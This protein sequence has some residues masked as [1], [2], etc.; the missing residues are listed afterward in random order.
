MLENK[1]QVMKK[2]PLLLLFLSTAF[3]GSAQTYSDDIAP[4]I[5]NNCTSCHRSGEIGPMSLTNYEEVSQW[6]QTIAY[7]TEAKYMPPWKPDKD[8]STFIGE[9]GLTEDQIQLIQDWVAAGTP[10]G[11]PANEP[12]VPTFPDGSQLGT[13]DLVLTMEEAYTVAGNNQDDYRVFVLPTSE[14]VD[15][16]IAAIE[17]RPGNASIVHHAL[18]AFDETGEAATLDAQTPEYGYFSYGDFGIG[19][20][21]FNTGYTPGILTVPYPA[22]IGDVLPAGADVLIQVHYAPVAS[23]ASDLSSVNIFFKDDNDPIQRPIQS[24]LVLPNILPN[25]WNDFYFLPNQEKTI[26]GS[27]Q[28]PADISLFQVY[29]HGHLLCK[30]WEIYAETTGGETIQLLKIE[31]WDFNWQGAYTFDRMKKIPAGSTVHIKASYDNTSNNPA[32]PN[33]PPQ[34]VSWGDGTND[35][36]Y[37]IVL[38]WVPYQT[39]DE[40]IVIGSGLTGTTETTAG[41]RATLYAPTPN[42]TSD[43]VRINYYLSGNAN[44]DLGIFTLDGKKVK[45]INQ[46]NR[47]ASGIYNETTNVSDLAT[48]TYLIVLEADGAKVTQKLVIV[49]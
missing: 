41:T 34:I 17:F 27:F 31:D 32:N 26:H 7:V 42:P 9:K 40:D 6:A 49:R 44:I 36:M 2:I 16:E 38:N 33:N 10:Q 11:D 30:D 15:R 21:D 47:M 20:P 19:I 1:I 46:T 29:P 37:V 39:G 22:G 48:G 3:F 13:P 28:V 35:E 5:Y 25:G 14:G 12:P 4:I 43:Q 24:N 23:E 8:Y 45:S 18:I